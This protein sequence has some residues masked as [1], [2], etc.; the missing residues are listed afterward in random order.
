MKEFIEVT[1]DNRV[2]VPHLGLTLRVIY[3]AIESQLTDKH[4]RNFVL[5]YKGTVIGKLR[6]KNDVV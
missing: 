5:E 6:R 1:R 3:G 2:I 4:K